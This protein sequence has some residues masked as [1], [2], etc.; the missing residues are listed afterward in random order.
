MWIIGH[1]LALLT[2]LSLGLIGGG[3]SILAVP[4]L[5]YIL[6]LDAKIAIAMS[7][8]V[9]GIVSAIGA[10]PHWQQGNVNLKTAIVFAPPAMLGAY[11]GARLAALPFVTD[12]LQLVCFA[13]IM[14]IASYFMIR[15][16]KAIAYQTHH[17]KH[18][19][20]LIALEGLAVGVI[21]GFVGV[22]GGFA[23]IPALVLLGGIP[24]KE[25]IGTS[26]L[27]IAFKSA[28]GFLGYLNQVNL[29]WNLL[30]SFTV[31][32]ALGVIGGARFTQ[33]ISGEQLQK[34]FGYFLIAI[35]IFILIK[36]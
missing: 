24:M 1:F 30:L 11:Y 20:L 34:A 7:L 9:V 2:G 26:L 6:K 17:Q 35:A 25:A 16:P 19:W 27:I 23:I 14:L 13:L 28:T 29:N 32:A 18:L 5:V 22:G 3:G 15:K 4:I 33:K 12:T 31:A 21:T 36:R 10:I 8:A